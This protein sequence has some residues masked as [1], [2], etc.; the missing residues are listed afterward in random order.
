MTRF[1]PLAASHLSLP[2][3]LS[4]FTLVLLTFICSCRIA[5]AQAPPCLDQIF[6]LQLRETYGCDL[7]SCPQ[8]GDH[9][10]Q[11][12][13][14]D[15]GY[16]NGQTLSHEATDRAATL[17]AQIHTG[18]MVPNFSSTHLP[19][20]SVPLQ[21]HRRPPSSMASLPQ[22]QHVNATWVPTQD[23]DSPQREL[24]GSPADFS[25]NSIRGAG[26]LR[27]SPLITRERQVC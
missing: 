24:P 4:P 1:R 12:L 19:I 11:P 13:P 9:A 16:P 17:Q 25:Q 21:Q 7:D 2:V 6:V 23:Y 15:N 10:P 18:A 27:S 8:R 22:V 20:A 5:L 14:I 3:T 26:L